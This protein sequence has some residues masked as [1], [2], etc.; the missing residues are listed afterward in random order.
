[1]PSKQNLSADNKIIRFVTYLWHSF[2]N[3]KIWS[4]SFSWEVMRSS[5]I[6][7]SKL[8]QQTFVLVKTYWRC[9]EDVVSV[10][11]VHEDVLKTSW[12]RLEEDA[13]Q[14]REDALQ[15]RFKDV[16]CKTKNCYAEDVFKTS[17]RRLGKLEMFGRK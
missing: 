1:M 6:S 5:S 13:L 16:F 15:T 3:N 12:R 17:W 10:R 4:K 8:T 11:H 7:I 2:P 9:L 14:T